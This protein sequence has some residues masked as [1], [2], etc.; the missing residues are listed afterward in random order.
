[1]FVYLCGKIDNYFVPKD[2]FSH[3]ETIP[4]VDL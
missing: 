1:M 2:P 3:I 4:S